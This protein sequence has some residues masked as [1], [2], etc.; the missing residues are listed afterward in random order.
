GRGAADRLPGFAGRGHEGVGRPPAAT[1]TARGRI[2]GGGGAGR[3]PGHRVARRTRRRR[4]QGASVGAG[5]G[6]RPV[7]TGAAGDLTTPPAI[8]R[9]R[10]RRT[11][12]ATGQD[13][14]PCSPTPRRGSVGRMSTAT[15]PNRTEL[16]HAIACA[17]RAPSVHNSQPWLFRVVDDGVEVFADWRRQLT[18]GDPSGRALRVS[19]G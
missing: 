19:C 13:S 17:T 14:R 4:H 10:L 3:E 8:W 9:L 16:L 15:L 18:V 6:A 12:G 1:G 7:A 5:R 2:A 11:V